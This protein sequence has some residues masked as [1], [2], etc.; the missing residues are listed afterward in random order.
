MEFW[1]MKK[2]ILYTLLS[3]C[4]FPSVASASDVVT[5][6]RT[7]SSEGFASADAFN[8][9]FPT[10]AFFEVSFAKT[11]KGATRITFSEG[12]YEENG[13]YYIYPPHKAT[14]FES[15]SM[16][17]SMAQKAGYKKIS[18]VRYKCDMTSLEV[19]RL[20]A[21]SSG[22]ASDSNSTRQQQNE[23]KSTGAM[24]LSKAKQECGGLG[25]KSG[26]EKFAD[27]VMKLLP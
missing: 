10:P 4:V 3:F 26:T 23:N 6:E 19:K 14:L 13:S 21:N 7:G 22:S 9:W 2:Y 8:S 1:I 17:V 5:C 20:L 11:V 24:S 25:Y 18:D 15:G 27:C 16:S 12:F